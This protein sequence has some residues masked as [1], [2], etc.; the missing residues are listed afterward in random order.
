V[1]RDARLR[2]MYPGGWAGA[3]ARRFARSW[4]VDF[5]LGLRPRRW[6]TLEAPGRPSPPPRGGARLG[7]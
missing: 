4:A 5:R 6:V 2:R 1:T 7:R 3:A